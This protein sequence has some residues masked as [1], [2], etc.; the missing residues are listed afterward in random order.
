M[1]LDSLSCSGLRRA[2]SAFASLLGKRARAYVCGQRVGL[3]MVGAE[4]AWLCRCPA[5]GG[6]LCTRYRRSGLGM[7]TC[8]G[9]NACGASGKVHGSVESV[10]ILG[11]DE[12]FSFHVLVQNG[13]LVLFLCCITR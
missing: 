10:V 8:T 3:G 7:G 5:C 6:G 11:V 9:V 12:S 1:H 2:V 4:C 13:V